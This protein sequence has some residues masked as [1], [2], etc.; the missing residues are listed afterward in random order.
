[1][2]KEKLNLSDGI[3]K[4]VQNTQK[5]ASRMYPRNETY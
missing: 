3:V 1:M 5:E 2:L 4:T